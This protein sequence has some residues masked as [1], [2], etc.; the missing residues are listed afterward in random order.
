MSLSA[1]SSIPQRTRYPRA[2]VQLNLADLS[3]TNASEAH[4]DA[5]WGVAW[6]NA[7]DRVIS[8]SADGT[9]KYL[10]S[11]SGQVAR[12]LP[13]HTLGLTSLSVSP[14]GRHTLFNS[15]EGLT[16]LWDLSSGEIVGKHE[17][18]IRTGSEP[19]EP[20]TSLDRTVNHN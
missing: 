6:S 9:I 19:V 20:C 15:I 1:E 8:I 4:D 16:Q 18:Y 2:Y 14:D 10:D 17:S 3:Q 11:T 5:V 13:R 12:T 7:D